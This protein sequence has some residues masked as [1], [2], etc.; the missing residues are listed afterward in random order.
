MTQPT[1]ADAGALAPKDRASRGADRAIALLVALLAALPFAR[2]LGHG[3]V[4]WDDDVNFEANAGY[5]GFGAD[6]L[7]WMWTSFHAGHYMP[8]TWMSCALDY[9]IAGLDPAQFHATSLA[10]HGLA[11]A[12]LYLG[13]VELLV[14]AGASAGA[15]RVRAA[16]ALGA[17]FFAAHPL[18][19][20]SVAWATERRDVLSGAFLAATLWTWL[21]SHR[22]ARTRARWLGLSIGFFAASLLSKVSGM[23]LPIVLLALDAWPLRR[24]ERTGWRPLIV[25]KLPYLALSIAAGAVG[26]VAQRAGTTVLASLEERSLLERVAISAH[27]LRFYLRKTLLPTG[28][29]PLYELPP[30]IDPLAARYSLALA[31]AVLVTLFLASRRRRPGAYATA[32][33]AWVAFV[34]LLAPV[35]GIVHAGRQIAADRYT[36]LP[37]FALAA[38]LASLLATV[39]RP[40]AAFSAV[41]LAVVALGAAAW[42]QT[43]WWRDTETLFRRIVAIEPASYLGWHKLGVL[44]HRKHDFDAALEHY[45]RALA[46][47]PKDGNADAHYDRAVTWHALGR[48]DQAGPDLQLALADD[49]CHPLALAMIGDLEIQFGRP[50]AA[51]EWVRRAV[52]HCPDR[53]EVHQELAR[54]CLELERFEEGLGAARRF[55]QLAPDDAWARQLE[56]LAL[57]GMQRYLE[58]E[59]PLR[60]SLDLARDPRLRAGALRGLERS[61]AGQGRTAEAAECRRRLD[62][63]R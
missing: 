55:V 31:F 48:I 21:R 40:L 41:G 12:L 3:F 25:E 15:T 18:R 9:A 11:A 4:A 52:Q 6:E 17:L 35:I 22:E 28:L 45:G 56:G 50:Q 58:A 30:G 2:A 46:A 19:V 63:L 14:A 7:R 24:V 29:S 47:R 33:T 43:G 5:R 20:E 10:L 60:T 54:R 59:P 34:V 42:R 39:R 62:E 32:W 26:I 61:L 44:A 57:L 53:A 16:A 49:P 27:A 38:A 1:P 13:I 23:T 51:L 8:L 37:S 36:Y